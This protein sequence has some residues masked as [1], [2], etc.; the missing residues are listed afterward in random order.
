MNATPPSQTPRDQQF[1]DGLATRR[2]VLGDAY[3]QAALDKVTPFTA[4]LQELVSRNAWGTVWQREG[5]SLRDRSM[6]TVA[7]AAALG[8]SKPS[9]RRYSCTCRC[10]A[11]FHSRWRRFVRPLR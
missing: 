3:V 9:S 10:I 1:E 6:V 8:R 5:L 11:A 7:M 2:Q 4:E